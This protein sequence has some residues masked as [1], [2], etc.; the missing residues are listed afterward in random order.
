MSRW[1]N[2]GR[3]TLIEGAIL[4]QNLEGAVKIMM[5][6]IQKQKNTTPQVVT[7]VGAASGLA[8]QPAPVPTPGYPTRRYP[9]PPYLPSG[10]TTIRRRPAFGPFPAPTQ[11][12]QGLA[13]P[14]DPGYPMRQYPRPPYLPPGAVTTRCNPAPGPFPAPTPAMQGIRPEGPPVRAP[15]ARKRQTGAEKELELPGETM[16]LPVRKR[17]KRDGVGAATEGQSGAATEGQVAFVTAEEAGMAPKGQAETA[18]EGQVE[19]GAEGQVAIVT[20]EEAGMAPKG[21]A[22]TAPEGQVATV[23]EEEAGMAPES[24]SAPDQTGKAGPS[25]GEVNSKRTQPEAEKAEN[26]VSPVEEAEWVSG[27]DWE[28]EEITNLGLEL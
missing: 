17:A 12:M 18:P 21:Q 13:P 16:T 20:A 5:H 25:A 7:G 1:L 2:L 9:R 24:Q 26:E 23:T 3:L 8:P 4:L 15:I 28:W 27:I 10:A 11:P 22:E 19:I 14:P 6:S